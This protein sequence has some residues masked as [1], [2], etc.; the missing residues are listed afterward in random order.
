MVDGPPL[1]LPAHLAPGGRPAPGD[2]PLCPGGLRQGAGEPGADDRRGHTPARPG[3]RYYVYRLTMGRHVQTGLVAAASVAAYDADRIKKHEFTRPVKEDDRVRQIDALNAQTGP[4][5]LVYR[6]DAGHRRDPGRGVRRRAG[7]RHHRRGRGA[8]RGLADGRCGHHR[9][10]DPR[11]RGPR[12]PLCRRR[13][14]PLRR[15]LPGRRRA[16][17]RQPRPHRGG[18][19]QLLPGGD[20]PPRPDAD[21]GLQPAGARPAR[22]GRGGLPCAGGGPLHGRAEPG[23]GPAGPPRRVRHVPGRVLVPPDPGP[24]AHPLGR[25]GGAAWTSACSRTT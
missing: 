1:E 13:T 5:F 19:L 7:G 20:L 25:P 22:A 23:A 2:R 10:P 3:P 8:P 4:V 15:R 6:G 9:R 12:R 24:G 14:P 21:P 16:P 18:A 11:L 17:G